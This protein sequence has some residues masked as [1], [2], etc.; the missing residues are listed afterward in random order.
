LKP[1]VPEKRVP[2]PQKVAI[3]VIAILNNPPQPKKLPSDYDR[4][5][6]K[7]HQQRNKKCGKTIPQLGTQQKELEPLRVPRMPDLHEAEFLAK[8]G[9]TPEQARGVKDDIHVAPVVAPNKH[10]KPFV[11]KEEEMSLGTQMFNLHKWYLRISNDE[12]KM[13]GVKFCD[14]DFFHGE[15][16]FWVYF[17]NL[18]HIYHRQALD[19]SIITIWVL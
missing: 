16:D 19:A 15:D 8:I 4:T 12:M 10:G 5:L 17:E 18:H 1:K 11:T 3:K 13:F 2:V 14:N 6:I 9:L 7:A